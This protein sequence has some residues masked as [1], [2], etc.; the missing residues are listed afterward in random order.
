MKRTKIIGTLGPK[1]RDPKV[2]E[3]LIHAGVNVFRVNFS[4]E[5]REFQSKIIDNIKEVRKKAGLSVAILQ[6]LSG[7]KIRIGD[8][9][10]EPV[11]LRDGEEFTLTTREIIG[12]SGIVTVNYPKLHEEAF[13]GEKI[14]LAD[15]TILL[16]VKDIQSQDLLCEVLAG[17][18]LYSKKGVNLP[19]TKISTPAL[20]EK[21]QLDLELGLEK[22]VDFVAQSFVRNVEDVKRVRDIIDRSGKRTTLI[23]KIEK[24]EALT[25]IDEILDVVDGI[26][27]A[28]GDLGVEIPIEKVPH[29][30]K[31]LIKKAN[32][33]GKISIVATQ[34]L[35]SMT[36]NPLPTRA[37]VTDVANAILDGAGAIMLSAETAMGKYPVKTVK[38]MSEIARSTEETFP[39]QEWNDKFDQDMSLSIQESVAKAACKIADQ[40]GAKGI[41]T[42][43]NSGS[44]TRYVA[45]YKPSQPI[46]ALTSDTKTFGKLALVWGAIPVYMEESDRLVEMEK[47]AELAA[48]RYLK[49]KKGDLIVITGGFTLYKAGGTNLI[50]ISKIE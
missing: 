5:T 18:E 31:Q 15:G 26:M 33:K 1:T 39:F 22:N 11:F 46:L 44:T 10:E 37:E 40:I 49:L 48:T 2:M 42:F 9:R 36:K 27:V 43:T 29:V 17:G 50:K 32:D 7:P 20:T 3:D 8:F 35:E 47:Q 12:D 14:F 45:K 13:V 30:Q 19:D 38:L 6:D 41:V 28:R 24:S 4:H 25:Q 16:K 23:A 34:M 21:D